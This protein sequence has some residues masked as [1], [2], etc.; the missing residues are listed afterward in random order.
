M[1]DNI[2]VSIEADKGATVKSPNFFEIEEIT[3]EGTTIADIEAGI[4]DGS[5]TP[6]DPDLYTYVGK[7]ST[8]YGQAPLEDLNLEIETVTIEGSPT[9]S[10]VNSYKV[11]KFTILPSRTALWDNKENQL[12][13]DVK[14]TEKAD[15]DNVDIW[16]RGTIQV[17]PVITE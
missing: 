6:K 7:V 4:L 9:G 15:A 13:F 16:I 3:E 8:D 17:R 1:S 2:I 11:L 14:R 5:Y 10:G 12:L